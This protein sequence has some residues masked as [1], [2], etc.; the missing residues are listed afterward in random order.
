MSPQELK[1]RARRIAE[2]LL[3]QGDRRPLRRSSPP[4]VCSH[5]IRARNSGPWVTALRRAF[6]DL[7]AVIKDE[8]AEDDTVAQRLT[9][10]GYPAGQF[11]GARRTSRLVTRRVLLIPAT[12]RRR[13]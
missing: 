11:C 9:I 13:P 10:T 2:E 6:P 5:S 1:A 12:G 7:C 4:T 3:T 8:I